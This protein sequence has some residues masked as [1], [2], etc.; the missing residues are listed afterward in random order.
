MVNVMRL[1]AQM[2]LD[3]SVNLRFPMH[4]MNPAHQLTG[5]PASNIPI[6]AV[7]VHEPVN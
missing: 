6:Y 2:L 7:H 4:V 3:V 1:P 5:P